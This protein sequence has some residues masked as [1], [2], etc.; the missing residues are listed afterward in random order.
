MRIFATSLSGLTFAASAALTIAASAALALVFSTPALAGELEDGIA[1]YEEQEYRTALGLLQPLA[2]QGIAQAQTYMGRMYDEGNGVVIDDLQ[3]IQWYRLAAEQRETEALF[4]LG[5]MYDFGEGVAEDN[6]QAVQWYRLA[7]AQEHVWSQELVDSYDKFSVDGEQLTYDTG[8]SEISSLDS[9]WLDDLLLA[10]PGI[11]MMQLTSDGGDILA[12]Y[13]M[14]D[15]IID[16][17][18]NTHVVGDCVSA[19]TIL[20]LAGE[21]R[22][23]QRGSRLGFHQTSWD[24]DNMAVYYE[25]QRRD[26]GWKSEFDF[27]AWVYLDATKDV[28][29]ELRYMLER[30]VDAEFAIKALDAEPDDMWHPRRAELEEAGVIRP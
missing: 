26:H 20:F 19:C 17:G 25:D 29:T 10:N 12:A 14:A 24:A 3:A 2:D 13:P 9:G 8:V 15:L 22:T 6:A 16:Y 21:A 5:T 11:T 4:L 27:A 28:L 7:A 1:A 23:M 30:G 18:L